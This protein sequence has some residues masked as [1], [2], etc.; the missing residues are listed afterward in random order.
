MAAPRSLAT[1]RPPLKCGPDFTVVRLSS[2]GDTLFATRMPY[3]PRALDRATAA[4]W[5]DPERDAPANKA[6]RVEIDAGEIR[7][8]MYRPRY[9]P[10]VESVGIGRNGWVWVQRT[11]SVADRTTELVVLSE[12]GALVGR[13][14]V[15]NGERFLQ[16]TDALLWTT[17]RGAADEPTLSLYRFK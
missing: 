4:Y 11:S 5:L 14:T 7:R 8:A 12:R 6:L 10:P 17:G 9:F 1:W 13:V 15:P 3:T 16:A 2:L